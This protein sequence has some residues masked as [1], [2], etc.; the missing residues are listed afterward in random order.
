MAAVI[1]II[2]KNKY[3][4]IRSLVVHPSFFRQGIARKLMEYALNNYET[5]LFV[6]ET[7]VDNEPASKLY[8]KLPTKCI[9]FDLQKACSNVIPRSSVNIFFSSPNPFDIF[10][11]IFKE[12]MIADFTKLCA[13]ISSNLCFLLLCPLHPQILHVYFFFCQRCIYN[14]FQCL[15][16]L[17][18]KKGYIQTYTYKY[19]MG[20][21]QS[22]LFIILTYSCLINKINLPIPPIKQKN[23]V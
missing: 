5:D 22:I 6:V 9:P 4:H 15:M 3:I 2:D 23:S 16:T 1:E 19:L 21:F 20:I 14:I 12:F 13:N 7:G 10:L 11:F 17:K 8:L 18:N